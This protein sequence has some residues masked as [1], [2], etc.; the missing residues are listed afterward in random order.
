MCLPVERVKQC[1]AEHFA[2]K[3]VVKIIK[4]RDKL[5]FKSGVNAIT[6]VRGHGLVN[7]NGQAPTR[8]S[9]VEAKPNCED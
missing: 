5:S 8:V 6:V 1:E 4:V 7:A 3:V 9:C 2:F